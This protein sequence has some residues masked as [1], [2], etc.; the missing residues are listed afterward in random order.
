MRLDQPTLHRPL[1]AAR[2]Y[3][4]LP[5]TVPGRA[6]QHPSTWIEAGFAAVKEAV[7]SV[8]ASRVTALGVSGQQHGCVPL[9][10]AGAPLRAA[11]LW[12]DT[13]T[14]PQ[15]AA[16]GKQWGLPLVPAFTASKVKWLLENE[17]ASLT[18]QIAHIVLPHDYVNYALTGVLAT[19]AG[20]ASGTGYW[21]AV[22][23]CYDASRAD[24]ISPSLSAWLPPVLPQTATVGTLTPSAAAATGLPATVRVSVGSGDNACAAL[25]V[26]AVTPGDWVVSLGTSGTLFGPLA[27]P[28]PP[29]VIASGAVAPFCDAAGGWLPLLCTLNCTLPAEEVRTSAKWTHA[30]AAAAATAIPP[31][32]N[33]VLFLPY[34]AGERTPD[35][36]HASGAVVGLKP[37]SASD[38]ATL[39]RAALEGATYGL[40]AGLDLLTA[41]G[42]PASR[43]RV[44]GGGA[45]SA[46]WRQIVSNVFQLPVVVPSETEAAALGAALQAAAV[47]EGA[48]SVR[49]YV[50]AAAPPLDSAGAVEPDSSTADAYAEA[51]T[52]FD[53]VGT[54]LFGEGGA[55]A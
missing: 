28:P 25:G 6:E 33:G 52:R 55:L 47:A 50:V 10:A 9:N 8:D 42:A 3:D 32:S 43:V 20:D 1:P 48:G 5:T 46:L 7:S 14:A 40:A 16:L 18:D 22:G 26:G 4:L 37:G 44:V 21:D 45:K 23:R 38:H 34:L 39:Y 12:C 54:A 11:K 13:E 36:P 49:E 2:P 51:R 41:K 35:W 19:D 24:S 53:R 30:E 29:S 27:T 15:A 17:P 31:A